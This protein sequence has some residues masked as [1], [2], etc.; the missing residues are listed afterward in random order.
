MSYT[1]FSE[2]LFSYVLFGVDSDDL[3]ECP[4]VLIWQQWKPNTKETHLSRHDNISR[5]MPH[6]GDGAAV[7]STQLLHGDQVLA[8]Q[9]ESE[10]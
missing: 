2:N 5:R 6:L 9:V 1:Q 10:L 3:W 8:A 7:A 4:K